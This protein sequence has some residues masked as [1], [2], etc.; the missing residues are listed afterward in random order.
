M[1][2]IPELPGNHVIARLS[3]EQVIRSLGHGDTRRSAAVVA[4]DMDSVWET[5]PPQ[6]CVD[7]SSMESFPASDPPARTCCHA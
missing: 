7:E 6:D 4:H 1:Y 5:E 3:H 2:A